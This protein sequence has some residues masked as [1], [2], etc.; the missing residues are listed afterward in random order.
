MFWEL[1]GD[2]KA[3][4]V[5][6]TFSALNNGQTLS[7]GTNPTIAPTASTAQ[8]NAPSST[9]AGSTTQ[10]PTGD[11][12]PWQAHKPYNVGDRVQHEGK[13]Y[14]C[15]Q[16]HTALPGWTPTAVPALWQAV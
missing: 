9:A 11:I 5:G 3:E 2:R 14:Q 6:A 4:L 13:V 7:P 1:S 8:T 16:S 15:L 12:L 10:A